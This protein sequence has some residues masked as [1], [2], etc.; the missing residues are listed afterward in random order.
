MIQRI[1][2]ELCLRVIAVDLQKQRQKQK[3]QHMTTATVNKT[4]DV[5]IKEYFEAMQ[6]EINPSI[7]YLETNQTSLDRLLAFHNNKALTKITRQYIISFLNSYKKSEEIDPLHKWIG[8]YNSR[9][10]NLLRFFIW[11]HNPTLTPNQRLKPEIF[12]NVPQLRR[13]ATRI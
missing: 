6:T 7:N 5:I 3:Q 8:T 13:K 1:I 11:L 2:N 12:H 4:N 10:R 9:L